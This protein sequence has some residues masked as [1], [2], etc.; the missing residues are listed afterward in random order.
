MLTTPYMHNS[1]AAVQIESRMTELLTGDSPKPVSLTWLVMH[2]FSVWVH[3]YLQF[4]RKK[5]YIYIPLV[6]WYMP[7]RISDPHNNNK[8]KTM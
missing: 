2:H 8:I 3:A 4:L 5:I 1:I 6:L 7:Y